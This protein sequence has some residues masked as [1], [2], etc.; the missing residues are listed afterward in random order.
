MKIAYYTEALGSYI[1]GGINV[2]V[3]ILN[4]LSKLGHETCCFV[5][6]P[7]FRS[8]W[9][10]ADFPI[11]PDESNIY[12]E[13]D[14]ILISPFSPTVKTVS[15]HKNSLDRLYH[16]NANEG[17]FTYNGPEW[18]NRAIESYRLP[19]KIFCVSSYLQIIMEQI[20]HRKIIGTL[21][22]PGYDPGVFNTEGRISYDDI[23]NILIFGRGHYIRGVDTA[24][25]A[26]KIAKQ[27]LPWLKLKIIPDGIRDRY[28]L[29]TYYKQSN[30]FLDIS[31]LAGSP[32]APKEALACG[33][34]PICTP[35]G[36]TDF[37]QTGYNGYIVPPD[38]PVAVANAI[39][40]YSLLSSFEQGDLYYNALASVEKYTW[41][42]IAQRLL[43]AVN[44]GLVRGSELLEPKKW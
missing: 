18:T 10:R 35:Y 25:E 20:Y 26:F 36:T 6:H 23:G 16:I 34:I 28:A 2:I 9:L 40:D 39:I 17:L 38:D 42:D 19:V 43:A 31:R 5:K 13:F 33:C 30:L 4:E 3:S 8:E 44:E 12:E 24:I 21:V 37:I 41:K 14:G 15:E 29:A 7:P 27:T 1:S 32:T 11:Y 22:P